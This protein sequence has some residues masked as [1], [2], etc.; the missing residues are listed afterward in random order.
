MK[1]TLQEVEEQLKKTNSPLRKRDLEKCKRK[2]LKEQ[3]KNE[4][5]RSKR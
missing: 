4:R 2:L 1:M 3:M 5:L